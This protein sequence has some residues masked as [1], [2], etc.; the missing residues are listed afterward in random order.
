MRRVIIFQP[1]A[2]PMQSGRGLEKGWVI[3]FERCEGQYI[4]PFM[5]WTGT[6]D[7]LATI[8]LHFRTETEAVAYVEKQGWDYVVRAPEVATSLTR[9]AHRYIDN[10]THSRRR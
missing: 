9:R 5:G 4:D 3:G 2:T 7:T 6:K 1:Q 8:R 10:F